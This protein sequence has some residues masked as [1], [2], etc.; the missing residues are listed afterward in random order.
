MTKSFGLA[1]ISILLAMF[2]ATGC[3]PHP[4]SAPPMPS[5]YFQTPFQDE[6]QY[7]VDA[8]VSDLAEQMYYAAFHRLPDS[9][10]FQVTAVEKSGSPLDAP[11]Y[12]LDVNLDPKVGAIKSELGI[13]GPIWSPAV[14][15]DLATQLANA[16]GLKATN[17]AASRDTSLLSKLTDGTPET[18]ER[19]NEELSAALE[20]NFTD[21]Q[22]HEE[23]AALLGAF[24]LRD[25]SGYF[26]DIR[27]PLSR[28]TAHLAMAQFLSGTNRYGINGQL[29][30]A[31]L[32]TLMNDESPAL[33]QLNA[34]G[35]NDAAI[36]PIVRALWTRDTGDY[37]LLGSMN[38]L[39]P[40]ESVE[41]FCAMADYVSPPLAWPKL[42]DVQQRTIDF[43]RIANQE[44]YSVEMGHDLLGVSLRLELTEIE[45]IYD[46]THHKSLEEHDLAGALNEMPERCFTKGPDGSVHVCVIGW[47][48]WAN[49]LQRHLCH[50][51]QSNFDFLQYRWGVPD[52]AKDFASKCDE[53]FSGLRLYPFVE[54][55]DATDVNAYHK[56]VDDG[57]KVTMATPQLTP[58][59]CWN[60]LCYSVDFAP[61][62]SPNPN[63]HVNEWHHHNPPPGTDYDL[64]PRLN[65]PSLV[66]RPDAI[67]FFEK[68][69]QLSP[70]DCR[71]IYFIISHKYGGHPTY[72]EAT[73]LYGGLL[74]YSLTAM[75][76]VANSVTNDPDRYESLMLQAA[77]LDPASY[78]T[79]GDYELNRNQED[80]AAGYFDK[81][82]STDPDSVS[83]ASY[84][85]WRVRHYLKKG[86]TFKARA[87]ADF[88]GEVYSYDGLEAEGIYFET[89]SN[90]PEAFDWYQ[91]IEDRYEDSSPLI[92]FCLRYKT[93]TGNTQFDQEL[94]KRLTKLFPNG[95][96]K[97]ALS[98]FHNPPADGVLIQ[99][100]NDRLRSAGLRRGD[101]IVA[102]N[103]TRTHTMNQY[104]CVRDSLTGPE[105][106]LI[107]W[108]DGAYHA[109]KA[110]PPNHLFGV[111]FGDYKSR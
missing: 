7:I 59:N 83:V 69:H 57:F 111:D 61:L 47:G 75:R 45:S 38:N 109:I 22:L 86:D 73:N 81:G 12:E 78:F 30:Q 110:S 15:Q 43:V 6:S 106:D 33:D 84:A 42:S 56:S 46:M 49:F 102:L 64:N 50:A 16:I 24:L 94:Q 52:D 10:D 96:E 63:P 36:A 27:A 2:W 8:V 85:P 44:D 23:A 48:Q 9:K 99:E 71:I 104:T 53:E 65:H 76:M 26:F 77:R 101:V 39:T 100:E 14:Y 79:L 5:G 55:F 34:I 92:A 31:M 74:P 35:T 29:A 32:L 18:I 62:Y 11:V 4:S 108:Q 20:Q 70:Y 13:N 87:I 67:A 66:D 25:H 88:G 54:R 37:R 21:P 28:M 80:K 98:D 105:L 17:A 97:V 95:L 82:A 51:I 107:V 90:Y 72:D 58:A 40:I 89:T 91:K 68:L 3:K 93:L 1:A 19:E 41:W 103:G 60:Y